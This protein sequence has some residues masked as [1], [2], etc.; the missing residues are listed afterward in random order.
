VTLGSLLL[1]DSTDGDPY[2]APTTGTH[3]RGNAVAQAERRMGR[4]NMY[5]SSKMTRT[6]G[7][8]CGTRRIEKLA[9]KGAIGQGEP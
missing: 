3:S 5:K 9:T 7:T 1:P 2:Q 8:A 6:Q 4:S